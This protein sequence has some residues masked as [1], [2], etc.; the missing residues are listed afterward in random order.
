VEITVN[1]NT[2]PKE[3]R[4]PFV[5]SGVRI[6]TPAITSRGLGPNDMETLG[7]LIASVVKNIDNQTELDKIRRGVL[8]LADRFPLYPEWSV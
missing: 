6:G 8:A 5:T 1:K 4:S 2:V 3:K 7:D